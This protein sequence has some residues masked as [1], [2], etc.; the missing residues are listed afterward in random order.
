LTHPQQFTDNII[1]ISLRYFIHGCVEGFDPRDHWQ[2]IEECIVYP[3]AHECAGK[4]KV[5]LIWNI[6]SSSKEEF[7]Q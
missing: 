5:I 4:Y 1:S 7:K 6:I 3:T 2:N